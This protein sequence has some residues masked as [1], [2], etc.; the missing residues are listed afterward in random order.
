MKINK[1]LIKELV[2]NLNEF[3]LTELEYQEGDRKIKVSKWAPPSVEKITTNVKLNTAKAVLNDDED[4]ARIK[5]PIIGTA[6]LSPE[7][8][9]KKFVEVGDIIKKGQTIMIIEAMKTMN[10]I[11]STSDGEV[12]KILIND[13]QPVEFGQPLIVLK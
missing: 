2:E 10:H 1:K 6:Y 8:G 9:A 13:G 7:P 12:K 11:P 3:G 5:S 4:G